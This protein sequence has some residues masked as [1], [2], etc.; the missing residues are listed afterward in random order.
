[1][2]ASNCLLVPVRVDA[3]VID[4]GNA[5][6]G[7][8]SARGDLYRVRD[9]LASP[10]PGPF[11]SSPYVPG[12]PPPEG[13]ADGVHVRWV[14]PAALRHAR[15]QDASDFLP[16]PDQWLLVRFCRTADNAA[17]ELM[18]WFIQSAVQSPDHDS[19]GNIIT[20]GFKVTEVG[21]ASPLSGATVASPVVTLTALGTAATGQPLFTSTVADHSD[22]FSFQD[23]L[24]GD[25]VSA[26][27]S[28]NSKTSLSYLVIGWTSSPNNDPL[29][30]LPQLMMSQPAGDSGGVNWQAPSTE[31]VLGALDWQLLGDVDAPGELLSGRS[32]FHGLTAAINYWDQPGDSGD[33]TARYWGT[34][35]GHPGSSPVAGSG[36]SGS[37]PVAQVGLGESAAGAVA[38]VVQNMTDAGTGAAGETL[39]ELLESALIGKHGQP[40]ESTAPHHP[41]IHRQQFKGLPAGVRWRVVAIEQDPGTPA[42]GGSQ[43]SSG[44]S[45]GA[46][47]ITPEINAQLDALNAAQRRLD[48]ACRNAM[49]FQQQLAGFWWWWA[50]NDLAHHLSGVTAAHRAATALVHDVN[51]QLPAKATPAKTLTSH[52]AAL[53]TTRNTAYTT[54]L[55]LLPAGQLELTWAPEATYAGVIDPVLAIGGLGPPMSAGG[56]GSLTCRLPGQV[57]KTATLK[58]DKATVPA[59]TAAATGDVKSNLGSVTPD[60]IQPVAGKLLVEAARF[61]S[62]LAALVSRSFGTKQTGHSRQVSNVSNF[63]TWVEEMN[64]ALASP[65]SAAGL[66]FK[67][68][69][70]LDVPAAS[71]GRL[72][73]Q[74]PWSPRFLDWQVSWSPIES[75]HGGFGSSW[76]F[77]GED[78]AP[79]AHFSSPATPYQVS[80]RTVASASTSDWID[81]A[82]DVLDQLLSKVNKTESTYTEA[83]NWKTAL[84]HLQQ[85]QLTMQPLGG[86][87]QRLMGR[88]VDAP[89]ARPGPAAD[90]LWHFSLPSDKQNLNLNTTEL[91]ALVLASVASGGSAPGSVQLPPLAAPSL[92]PPDALAPHATAS[93]PEPLPA[94]L[95]RSGVLKIEKLWL[96]DDFGQ[97]VDL[98]DPS[99]G[100]AMSTSI[101]VDPR[102]QTPQA[103]ARTAALP[104]RAL[105]PG[106][107]SF[108]LLSASDPSTPAGESPEDN[109]ICGWVIYNHLDQGLIFYDQLGRIQGELELR[110][111]GS[112][113]W[114][115]LADPGSEVTLDDLPNPTLKAF[116]K[117]LDGPDL[118]A[119]MDVIDQALPLVTPAG[120]RAGADA[121]LLAGR[122]LAIVNARVSLELF[123]DSA[124]LDP[125]DKLPKGYAPP[126]GSSSAPGTGDAILDALKLPIRLGYSSYAQ[127]SFIGAYSWQ[128][129]D[130]SPADFGRLVPFDGFEPVTED[131]P[132]KTAEGDFISAQPAGSG[133]S[134]TSSTTWP[135][136]VSFKNPRTLTL[137]IDPRGTV[138]ANAGIFP[139]QT[140][141]VSRTHLTQPLR[142][143]ELSLRIGPVIDRG[144][145][146]GLP[147]P[148]ARAGSWWCRA[149]DD[150]DNAGQRP[151]HPH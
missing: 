89:R 13:S 130:L 149:R 26:L 95:I 1:M 107:L 102:I 53:A 23:P 12:T 14:I 51:A 20:E 81:Q 37:T 142:N 25:Q 113:E 140:L 114:E 129:D 136:T 133:A 73:G 34:K 103:T 119:L 134:G 139:A 112:P 77:Q 92:A 5:G 35:L 110:Q 99:P 111:N 151:A 148:T 116:A 131:G 60:A 71:V 40:G 31:D 83:Q 91:A 7:W 64:K 88:N 4:A 47:Q 17:P 101:A 55:A 62:A 144:P 137:L 75:S 79:A 108:S 19:V 84:T 46:A 123:G 135:V 128:T 141:Q 117:A 8:S 56:D 80:G 54:L 52:I 44:A 122:P 98:T 120:P 9:E 121:A 82:I 50:Y 10:G 42:H 68:A 28:G 3:L 57:V 39:Y 97:Y 109:P 124:W 66:T 94:S 132:L 106:K 146:P 63:T 74:Q 93:P 22:V 49:V 96:V 33:S 100:A 58:W 104:P 105:Q 69:G 11:F 30:S 126:L 21:V 65:T 78:Y 72:W 118:A 87:H 15:G 125:R 70:A 41:D 115:C 67:A 138:Q 38:A 150:D 86:F 2:S 24:S 43:S 143:M 32:V 59:A 18:A 145:R 48:Q 16:L 85:A 29:A 61:E 76:S 6:D 90:S 127:D 45:P 36:M 27:K 147:I